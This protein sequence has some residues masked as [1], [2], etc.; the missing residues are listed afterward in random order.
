M[1]KNIQ[2]RAL[3]LTQQIM[4]HWYALDTSSVKTAL[5]DNASWIGAATGQ[6]YIGKDNVVQALET[7]CD[8]MMPCKVTGQTYAIADSGPDWC[9]VAGRINVTLENDAMMLCEPQRL[10]FVWRIHNSRLLLSHMHVSNNAAVVAP[11]EEFPIKA[12]R[13]AYEYLRSHLSDDMVNITASDRSLYRIDRNTVKYLSADNE[14]MIIHS[15]NEDIRVHRDLNSV[16]ENLFPD[17]LVIH[18]SYC[19]NPACLRHIRQFEAEMSDGTIL[20]IAKQRY[21]DVC[22]KLGVQL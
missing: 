15:E 3:L 11:D 21:T 14:Y 9:I 18:R 1:K 13:A 22:D 8:D 20:P 4:E 16:R 10:T 7:V 17:F 12:S 2:D 19:I 6:F 5:D